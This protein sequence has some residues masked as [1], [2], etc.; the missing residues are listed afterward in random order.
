MNAFFA[1]LLFWGAVLL[2]IAIRHGRSVHS[3]QTKR[4]SS[5]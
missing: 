3:T 2:C 4:D 1:T 5:K